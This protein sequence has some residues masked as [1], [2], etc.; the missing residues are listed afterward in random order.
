ME[1]KIMKQVAI[2]GY[3][4]HDGTFL[5]SQ[6]HGAPSG[7]PRGVHVTVQC[8]VPEDA[9]HWWLDLLNDDLKDRVSAKKEPRS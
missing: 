6:Y 9:D 4:A 8:S 2:R 7:A 5:P 3:R 1:R